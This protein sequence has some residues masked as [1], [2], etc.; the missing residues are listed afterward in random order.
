[1]GSYLFKWYVA[2]T[3]AQKLLYSA[4]SVLL[5][6]RLFN[7]AALCVLTAHR[8]HPASEVYVTGTFDDWGKTVKLDK[9]GDIF[10]KLVSLPKTS[11]KIFYKVSCSLDFSLITHAL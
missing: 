3:S 8:T 9:N 2:D 11:E 7:T 10:E 1:M 6:A 5:A 4:N